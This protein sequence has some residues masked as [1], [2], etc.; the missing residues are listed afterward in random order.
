MDAIKELGKKIIS[1]APTIGSV[2]LG[3]AGTAGG[4][5][6]K[7]LASA[8]DLSEDSSPEDILNA[9]SADPEI[10]LKSKIADQNFSVRLKEIELDELKARLADVQSA[11]NRQV[12]SEKATGKRDSHLYFLAYLYIAGFFIST[13][14]MI[15]AVCTNHFPKDIPQAAVFLL[16]NLF[17]A[18]TAG[19]GAVV[20]YFFGSS[21][22]SSDK[23]QTM[24]NL[25][26][27]VQRSTK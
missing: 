11:R 7:A 10:V 27:N 20:Q 1:F 24:T 19:S 4:V 15:W 23:T 26:G 18:L 14:I 17:G 21:K 25:F 9:V 5:A 6:I 16:G 2:L 13:A 8:F 12:E 3:P 22:S